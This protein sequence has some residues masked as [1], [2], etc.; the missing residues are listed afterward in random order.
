MAV[1]GGERKIDIPKI[2]V[3]ADCLGRGFPPTAI[4][5]ICGACAG[6]GKIQVQQ[7]LFSIKQDCNYCAGT[8]KIVTTPC[9]TCAGNGNLEFSTALVVQIPPGADSGTILRYKG[10]G[11]AGLRGGLPGD[12]RVVLNVRDDPIFAR[13]GQNITLTVPISIIDACL[14]CE[15]LFPTLEGKMKLNIP[16]GTQSGV[17]FIFPGL[18]APELPNGGNRGD[19]IVIVQV[20]TPR[21]LSEDQK[22]LLS[23]FG[24]RLQPKNQPEIRRFKRHSGT[25]T[26]EDYVD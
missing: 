18:G 7:G 23:S 24:N 2:K 10:E 11:Y 22:E 17:K 3:C 26:A 8:G 16:A 6:R 4:P 21:D 12:L 15:F 20:E 9:E 19:Q 13:D 14:G 1:L 25:L 5:E